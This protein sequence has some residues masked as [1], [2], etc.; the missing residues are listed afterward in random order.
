LLRCGGIATCLLPLKT[1]ENFKI[2]NSKVFFEGIKGPLG[3]FVMKKN[4][5]LA[6][7]VGGNSNIILFSPHIWGR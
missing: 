2:A 4:S 1:F 3:S 7:L 5:K 6:K